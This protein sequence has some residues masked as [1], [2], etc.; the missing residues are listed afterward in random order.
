MR[1][2]IFYDFYGVFVWV[3]HKKHR[4]GEINKAVENLFSFR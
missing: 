1:Y 3:L 2:A 4:L